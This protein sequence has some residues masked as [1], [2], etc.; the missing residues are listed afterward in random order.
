MGSS[1]ARGWSR[2][3]IMIVLVVAVLLVLWHRPEPFAATGWLADYGDF[4]SETAPPLTPEVS[5]LLFVNPTPALVTIETTGSARL[6]LKDGK[7]V[8]GAPGQSVDDVWALIPTQHR[9][10]LRNA[11]GEGAYLSV[12]T[13][14][15]CTLGLSSNPEPHWIIEP[16]KPMQHGVFHIFASTCKDGKRRYLTRIDGTLA[17]TTDVVTPWS[18]AVVGTAEHSVVPSTPPPLNSAQPLP[19]A[20][21]LT[22][23]SATPLTSVQPLPSATPRSQTY[24]PT[25]PTARPLP[26]ATPRSQTYAPTL[27]TVQPLPSATPRSPTYAPTLPT[28]RPLP[29]ATPRSQTY[30]P[31]LTTVQPVPSAT[32]RSQTYAPTLTSAQ[33]LPSATP[34]S[35][36]YAP[37]LTTVQPLPSATPRTPLS[38][39]QPLPNATPRSQTPSATSV[40]QSI[41]RAP[42]TLASSPTGPRTVAFR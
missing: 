3:W 19:S 12:D 25:L 37:T 36:T 40:T 41:P 34:R 10:C 33:P 24:A 23:P 9:Y 39:A 4:A 32:P 35:Q 31:T 15:G 2:G 11:G 6:A 22:S 26:S 7:P 21:P 38:T 5:T 18:I 27:T 28:V 30:A 20:T 16:V 42:F 1:W 29:S 14:S 8:V 17:L 13:I